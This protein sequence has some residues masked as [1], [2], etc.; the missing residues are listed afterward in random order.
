LADVVALHLVAI[1]AREE[2]K[3]IDGFTPSAM[4]GRSNPR[5][6]PITARTMGRAVLPSC[7]V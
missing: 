2:R 3:L 7:A 6:N 5:A 4:T 1:R